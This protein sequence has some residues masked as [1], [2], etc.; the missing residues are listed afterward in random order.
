MTDDFVEAGYLRDIARAALTTSQRRAYIDAV[1]YHDGPNWSLA[2]RTVMRNKLAAAMQP[3]VRR[4]AKQLLRQG[5]VLDA[6]FADLIQAGNIGLMQGLAT[7]KP[8][9]GAKLSSWCAWSI[10]RE[11][12]RE[13]DRAPV[14][15]HTNFADV[16]TYDEAPYSSALEDDFE[17][18]NGANEYAITSADDPEPAALL[19][20]GSGALADIWNEELSRGEA[21]A[22]EYLYWQDMSTREAGEKL[23]I[24]HTRVA[25][26]HATALEKYRAAFTKR[27]VNGNYSL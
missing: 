2:Q 20:Q 7:W 22:L 8:D 9:G 15:P 1:Y 18:W 26:L 19:W 14:V 4:C 27:G 3:L 6:D 12:T 13:N 23:K 24:S 21:W 5:R 17:A 25:Q 10:K 16:E 11:M